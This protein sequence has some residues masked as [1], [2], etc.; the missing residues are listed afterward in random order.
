MNDRPP[1]TNHRAQVQAELRA[2]QERLANLKTGMLATTS[3][4]ATL[5]QLLAAVETMQLGVT[6]TD[7]SGLILYANPAQARM[8][9]HEAP[10]A[11]VGRDVGVLCLPGYRDRLTPG[12]LL[13]MRSWGRESVN[14]RQDGSLVPVRLLSDVV[15]GPDGEPI[16]VI[17]TCEDLTEAKQVETERSRVFPDTPSP[18]TD[19]STAPSLETDTEATT[20]APSRPG[21]LPGRAGLRWWFPV[22]VGKLCPHCGERTL[23]ART[24]GH[25]RL[26]RILLPMHSRM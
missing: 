5:D 22:S 19:R 3:S 16:G 18:L 24:T 23:R 21:M 7:E 26:I 6:I 11:L 8:L 15:R 9:N 17:T 1:T 13:Q 2:F 12:R 14:V 25:T 10:E 4:G 20:R